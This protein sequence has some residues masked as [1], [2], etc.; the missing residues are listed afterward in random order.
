MEKW[1]PFK[2]ECAL[3]IARSADKSFT[4]LPLVESFQKDS[5]CDWVK[6][7]IFIKAAGPMVEKLK[8]FLK[9]LH[10]VGVMGVEFFLTRKGLIINEIAPRVHNTGHYSQ[11]TPGWSQFDLHNMCL[12]GQK[13]PKEIK[14]KGG[15][16]MANLIGSGAE[17][18]LKPVGG[19][20]W[21]GKSENRRG[22]K[23]GHINVLASSPGKALKQVS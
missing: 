16:A 10:Y 13:L 7:P 1:I 11:A 3:M 21:Y 22:R 14:I 2:R 8:S 17:V 15:F 9:R 20:H 6:G 5:R 12:L 4:H 19:L 18:K 23:M